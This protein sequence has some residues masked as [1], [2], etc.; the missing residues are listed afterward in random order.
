MG[1]KKGI[2]PRPYTKKEENQLIKIP[3]GRP[4][5]IKA[6][7]LEWNR[8]EGSTAEKH[9][10][11]HGYIPTKNK[12]PPQSPV[13]SKARANGITAMVFKDIE[14]DEKN[15]RVNPDEIIAMQKGLDDAI[16][17]PLANPK[18]AIL[19][20]SRMINRAKQ[21]FAKKYA[22]NVFSFHTNKK[23]KKFMLLRKVS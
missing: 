22:R 19:F 13:A 21:Y 18:R 8:T 5:L 11:L 15:M 14:F 12:I 3:E 4:D 2:S 9:K 7:A 6:F 16:T 10:R 20:P 23:D 17:G 1:T